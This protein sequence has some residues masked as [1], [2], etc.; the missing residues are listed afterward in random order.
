MLIMNYL[1]YGYDFTAIVYMKYIEFLL[2][3]YTPTML[4]KNCRR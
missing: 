3:N 4:K 2:A 1:D